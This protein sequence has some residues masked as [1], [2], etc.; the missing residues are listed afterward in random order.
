MTSRLHSFQAAFA[1]RGRLPN[2]G[3]F[4]L[5]LLLPAVA[6]AQMR[7]ATG[8]YTGSGSGSRAISVGFKPD[9]VILKGNNNEFTV[10]S[11]S[12]M[13]GSV[14][15]LGKNT[16]LMSGVI[17]SLDAT[18][19]TITSDPHVNTNGTTYYWAAFAAYAGEMKV[20]T[21]LG[22]GLDNV[23]ITG[24]GFQPSYVIVMSNSGQDAM[25]RF[26]SQAGDASR[27]FQA[28]DDKSDRIQAFESNGFQVGKHNTVNELGKTFHYVAFKG[29]S[30]RVGGN[31]YLGDG[32]DNRNVTDPGF[33]PEYLL[34]SRRLNGSPTVQRFGVMSGDA[35][36]PLIDTPQFTNGIQTLLPDG[37]QVGTV[38][39]VNK[40]ADLYYWVAFRN[41]PAMDLALTKTADAST[42]NEGDTLTYTIT[43]TNN[44]PL[45][46]TGVEV[47]DKLPSGLSYLSFIPSQGAYDNAS[48]IWRLGALSS[49]SHASLDLLA[50]V[51]AETGGDSLTNIAVITG[52][53]QSDALPENDADSV[54]VAVKEPPRADLALTQ[55][56]NDPNPN[57][58]D[59]LT[60]TLAVS[61]NGPDPAT[62]IVVRDVLPGG[63][64]FVSSSAL[65][66]A[67]DR[68]TGGWSIGPLAVGQS[69]RAYLRATVNMDAAGTTISNT[70]FVFKADQV[71]RVPGN[72]SATVDV[73]VQKPLL[74]TATGQTTASF[75]PGA[76]AREVL[77]FSV[78][79]QSARAETLT[80]IRVINAT[81]GPG[82]VSERD[83]EWSSLSLQI[84]SGAESGKILGTAAFSGGLTTFSGWALVVSAGQSVSLSIKGGASLKARDGDVL[85]ASLSGPEAFT[86]SRFV[87]LEAGG[88]L[89]PDGG[90]PVDGMAA[91]QIIVNSVSIKNFTAGTE[92]NLA[93]D[94]VLP[95][96]GYE[97]DLLQRMDVANLGDALPGSDI[98][99]MEIWADR[100]APG[101]NAAE[102]LRLG[103][104][105]FTGQRW[106]ITGLSEPVPQT[107][108][109][110]FVSV[111][112]NPLTTRVGTIQLQIP[113]MVSSGVGM[114]SGN[115][116]PLDKPVSNPEIIT[117][118]TLDKIVIAANALPSGITHPGDE[119]RALGF[120]VLTNTYATAKQLVSLT[121]S[122]LTSGTGSTAELDGEFERLVLYED[123]NKNGSF[124][125]AAVD[126]P[127][128]TGVFLDRRARF[129]GLSVAFA[130]GETRHLFVRGDISLH[131][132]ADGDELAVSVSGPLDADFSTP[133][134]VVGS[135]PVQS[136]ARWTVDGMS[137]AQVVVQGGM[138]A[139]VGP[140]DGPIPAL[141]IIVPRNGYKPDVL[142]GLSLI[143]LGSALPAD[144]AELRLWMDGGN[145]VADNGAGDDADLGTLTWNG[146]T[147][148]S[149]TM[150]VPIPANGLR[151]YVG[152]TL[153][154]SFPDSSGTVRLAVPEQGIVVGSQNDGPL[155]G[156]V[157]GADEFLLST[158][159]L[160]ATLQISSSASTVGQTVTMRMVVQNQGSEAIG[161]IV[162]SSLQL[163]GDG[164]LTLVSGPAPASLNLLPASRDTLTWS[165]QASAAGS[166]RMS[167]QVSGTG[168]VSSL[169]RGSLPALSPLHHVFI[170]A[171]ELRLTPVESMPFSVN[172]GQVGVVPLSL[173]F[174]NPG[175]PGSSDVELTHLRLRVEDEAG[176]DIAP[177]TVFS[178]V[179]LSEGQKIYQDKT[180]L[181]TSGADI[182]LPLG[183]PFS[184]IVVTSG[185]PTTLSLRF[186]M[187]S[188]ASVSKFRI[189][190]SSETSMQAKDRNSGAPVSFVL[191]QGVYPIRSGVATILAPATSV[192][193]SA[194]PVASS[195]AGPG[196]TRVPLLSFDLENVGTTGVT[197]SARVARFA[198]ALN[199]TAGNPISNPTQFLK[200]LHVEAGGDIHAVQLVVP[201]DGDSVVLVL[202]PVTLAV[203]SPERFDVFGDITDSPDFGTFRTVL[204]GP[205]SFAVADASTGIMVPVS[206]RGGP[207]AG[208][209]V[210]V[211]QPS[212]VLAV[213]GIPEF[214]G[215]VTIGTRNVP[216]LSV[217]LRH[218]SPVGTADIS[219]RDLLI[220]CRDDRGQLLSPS[221][222]L[223]GVRIRWNGADVANVGSL[224]STQ[225]LIPITL[226]NVAL[227]PGQTGQLDVIVDIDAG[228][229]ASRLQ[230][231]IQGSD[232]HAVDANIASSVEVQPEPGQ[233]LPLVS[234]LT[235]LESP[236]RTITVALT[237]MIPATVAPDSQWIAAGRIELENPTTGGAGAITVTS[238]RIEAADR[239]FAPFNLGRVVK[240]LALIRNGNVVASQ[241]GFTADSTSAHLVFSGGL[242]VDP[243]QTATLDLRLRLQDSPS[244]TG[245]RVGFDGS[246]IG[247]E[248]PSGA[249]L[250]IEA[251]P[252]SGQSF[253]MWTNAASLS[254]ASLDA[255]YSNFPN[256]F[257]AG[258]ENTTFAFY[259]PE[260]GRVTLRI[261]TPRGDEVLTLI[262]ENRAAGMYQSDRWDGRNGKG[263]SVVNGVYV[264]EL[265]VRFDNGESRRLLRKIGVRR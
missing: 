8:T 208:G 123:L 214:P 88:S 165:Y 257:A 61:N 126:P 182:D 134:A 247:I 192:E 87:R 90:F 235:Q 154:S 186:D 204:R 71:D 184:P 176:R 1:T 97:A 164:G 220:G 201:S 233:S 128:A 11:T 167:G 22:T 139:T 2:L 106:E 169:P 80:A 83:A 206:F 96:N 194:G 185:E 127:I 85:D 188:V 20:G 101:F 232:I 258:R 177:A 125:G 54:T 231:T 44:G 148:Q 98:E 68:A 117:I 89:D 78:N 172:L 35:T 118:S 178:R 244:G 221:V 27:T 50:R 59:T 153:S 57:E 15:E 69:V 227:E 63:L 32:T 237:S 141:D 131:G 26:P 76:L 261:W 41:T 92:R 28:N 120:F 73:I 251:R 260:P 252:V 52:S 33:R 147:W 124:D 207:I 46:A 60:F 248:Q 136:G 53:D 110:V 213:S 132:A 66:G 81:V 157:T 51:N 219:I 249:L 203:N 135:W 256:P 250:S 160:L 224:P 151:L 216:A 171:V 111:D 37:F 149:L 29:V 142:N 112:I 143:N 109:R 217:H 152:M 218:P 189:V 115:N 31:I 19:F 234:G 75:L 166:V 211:E 95:A 43:V 6:S 36:L 82:S 168:E 181:E 21:Y 180:S 25:Q 34:V 24:V 229:P 67:Y 202:S 104:M 161:N 38:D 30:G 209:N 196:Q 102:D 138:T 4:F 10:A 100:G 265:E 222:Y 39:P 86:F 246:G 113:S 42:P 5:C 9:L 199:D 7:V 200:Q 259:L 198:I 210:T 190:I 212:Q 116:G 99:T 47:L 93:L 14:K 173:T 236:P 191:E 79:N 241:F 255:S 195:T 205:T 3:L 48:G 264:A 162:P 193:A 245:F 84:V 155:D 122:S 144:L 64:T 12:T 226:P 107:G 179:V 72:E 17:Q 150:A 254:Q 197:S 187:A 159:P 74:V 130:P 45:G 238:L 239:D 223:D 215:A 145:G 228:S 140:G 243:A 62:G 133:T 158:S 23:S 13:S 121:L 103:P 55:V 114:A 70:A 170:E 56:V 146:T 263:V 94:V 183:A 58:G 49:G 108:L 91:A 40:A 77:R 65:Q 225:T 105:E 174:T 175:G 163:I 119:D 240:D 16:A 156:N 253:P 242:V 137:A 129:G 262:D 18:G 230:L